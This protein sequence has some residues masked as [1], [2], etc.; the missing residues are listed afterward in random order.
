MVSSLIH[1]VWDCPPNIPS[2]IRR[3]WL[4]LR[5]TCAAA[6]KGIVARALS[7]FEAV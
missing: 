1:D 3:A 5:S 6:T 7:R 4:L 2:D